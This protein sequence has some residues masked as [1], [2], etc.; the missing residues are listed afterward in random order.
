M[1]LAA[2]VDDTLEGLVKGQAASQLEVQQFV[3]A[4]ALDK[5]ITNA[6]ISRV[7]TKLGDMAHKLTTSLQEQRTH[8]HQ[9]SAASG[10]SFTGKTAEI[11]ST[12]ALHH[13]QLS[14]TCAEM[15]CRIMEY[16]AEYDQRLRAIF[17]ST[18]EVEHTTTTAMKRFDENLTES[19]AVL[20]KGL[21]AL[22]ISIPEQ[23]RLVE[24]Q[25][26]AR[27]VVVDKRFEGDRV[28]MLELT[29]ALGSRITAKTTELN[30][31]VRTLEEQTKDAAGV[32]DVMLNEN[33]AQL[34]TALNDRSIR[35]DQRLDILE[36][37]GSTIQQEVRKTSKNL[38][39]LDGSVQNLQRETGEAVA[40]IDQQFVTRGAKVD[41]KLRL[42]QERVQDSAK[43]LRTTIIQTASTATLATDELT[44][45]LSNTEENQEKGLA[46]MVAKLDIIEQKAE[47]D[48]DNQKRSNKALDEKL[49]Q[50]ITTNESRLANHQKQRQDDMADVAKKIEEGATSL[51]SRMG[52]FTE[53]VTGGMKN[54]ALQYDEKHDMATKATLECNSLI[55]RTG[56]NL[57]LLCNGMEKRFSGKDSLL[58]KQLGELRHR[59]QERQ[60]EWTHS[61][62]ELEAVVH[63]KHMQHEKHADEQWQLLSVGT[64]E[65]EKRLT[66]TAQEQTERREEIRAELL[67]SIEVCEERQVTQGERLSALI[68][69]NS[70]DLELLKESVG[71]SVEDLQLKATSQG[72]K[73]LSL[74]NEH[75]SRIDH[76][77]AQSKAQIDHLSE[78]ARESTAK[79]TTEI[80]AIKQALDTESRKSV[81]AL[82]TLDE[83][84]T[85]LTSDSRS[86]LHETNSR[87][88]AR[89]YLIDRMAE[90]QLQHNS[91]EFTTLKSG[92][93]Y[94]L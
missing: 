69:T 9:I 83:R 58:E 34:R 82:E 7:D 27:G 26:R 2:Q 13:T 55:D 56:A 20:S 60:Q 8:F 93:F 57:S 19:S 75:G 68:S 10:S 29:S 73:L 48:S 49:S 90:D 84:V 12:I 91:E 61:H 72:T 64:T 50:R 46:S 38:E 51:D 32:L 21:E 70:K 4:V 78:S 71:S 66:G 25:Q 6:A 3:V 17:S 77:A 36:R 87:L 15:N 63:D 11:D 43:D 76:T 30:A 86:A 54:M 24:E 47:T 45:R 42:L 85:T 31:M 33:C 18:A 89:L 35:I 94:A 23:M 41:E 81:N 39:L 80:S 92:A 74:Q 16:N 5:E 53:K 59:L 67:R 22:K 37:D 65:L 79:T 40:R 28:H 14:K 44:A 1:Q 52:T 62:H 88:V